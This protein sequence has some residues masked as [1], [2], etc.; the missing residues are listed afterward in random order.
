M[1]LRLESGNSEAAVVR[2]IRFFTRAISSRFPSFPPSS[3]FTLFFRVGKVKAE[4]SRSWTPR[5]PMVEATDARHGHNSGRSCLPSLR[6][7]PL[8]RL[9]PQPIV[10]SVL[11][12]VADVFRD[13]S[14]KMGFVE[15]DHVVPAIPCGSSPPTVRQLRSARDSDRRF[16]LARCVGP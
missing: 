5:V 12:I 15:D 9:F 16:G 8:G 10:S 1:C 6:G 11:M 4:S 13:Q 14:A 3:L 7:P 2:R